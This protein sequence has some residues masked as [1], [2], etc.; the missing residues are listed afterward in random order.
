MSMTMEGVGAMA[1]GALILIV[2]FSIIP[3]VGDQ[4]GR[5]VSLPGCSN[6]TDAASCA[7]SPELGGKWNS[8]VNTAIPTGVDLWQS[9][10]GILKVAGIIVVVAGFLRTL[11]GM[12][13]EN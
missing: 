9:I 1:I 2:A 6:N 13:S 11:Q 7:A 3:I 5:A 4:V 12:K 10:G 8:S